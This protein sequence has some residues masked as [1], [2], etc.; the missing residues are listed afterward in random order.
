MNTFLK[1]FT[2]ELI[3]LHEKGVTRYKEETS[4]NIK[5]HTLICTVDSV[6][7]PS[8]INSKQFNGKY[9]CSFCYHKGE[10][11][12][13]GGG[14]TTLYPCEMGKLRTVGEHY[15]HAKEAEDLEMSVMGVKG[16]SIASTIPCFSIIDS[17][18]P[19]YMHY[20]LLGV[21]KTFV[22]AWFNL[23]NSN[24]Q[25]YIGKAITEVEIRLLAI[26]PPSKITRTPRKLTDR[27]LW[28]AHEWKT[29]L[30][31]Y[32]LLCLEGYLP[33]KYLNHWFLLVYS[34]RILL[35][36]RITPIELKKAS[37]VI[38]RFV[39]SIETLYG[40]ELCKFNSH[41][42]LHFERATKLFGALWDS[43]TFSA[44]HYNSVLARM[45]R[46][47]QSIPEQICK[48]YNRFRKI[49]DESLY[50]FS[51]PECREDVKNL[52]V[53]LL[54]NV[55]VSQMCIEEGETLRI[56]GAY[57]YSKLSMIEK[58]VIEVLLDEEINVVAKLF[59][60]FIQENVLSHGN[61]QNA[62]EKRQNSCALLKNGMI[63]LIKHI[64]QIKT[65]QDHEKYVIL[66]NIY[67]E[68]E[69]RACIA[70][71]HVVRISTDGIFHICDLTQN[72]LVCYA[73]DIQE[74]MI[75]MPYSD[76]YCITKLVNNIEK[77]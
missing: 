21:V 42:L 61:D 2:D 29:F 70:N 32:S 58:N 76:H 55:K 34:I 31:Y 35:Q 3:D 50:T 1:P 43:S 75:C 59:N 33:R 53:K 47:S 52:Y 39:L 36:P 62:L 74:K 11:I 48:S 23:S 5:V 56:F 16:F 27:K 67:E 73:S 17:F 30:C 26:Q 72:I 12:A 69:R 65:L 68:V 40:K 54:G 20:L 24:Q 22:D 28:E 57:Q 15:D 37:E 38:L 7:R 19:D 25:W 14:F 49:E 4:I 63:V 6:A 71:D 64:V 13:V 18:V 41:L 10:T 77:D 46:N 60:R 44:E 66:A 45:F 8:I 51:N 9:G